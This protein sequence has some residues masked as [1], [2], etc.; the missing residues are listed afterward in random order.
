MQNYRDYLRVDQYLQDF[1]QTQMLKGALDNGL[2]DALIK[3]PSDFASLQKIS[4]TDAPGLSFLLKALLHSGVIIEAGKHFSLSPDFIEVLPYRSLI[5]AKI[6]FANL[7]APDLLEHLD[8]LLSDEEKFMQNSHLFE[9]FDYQRAL[10]STPENYRF[11]ERW[12]KLT[13]TLTRYEG[14]ACL[15]H[16]DFSS[17]QKIMDIGGNSGE[18]VLQ[19]TRQYAQLQAIVIDLPV[20]CEVGSQHVGN[21]REAERIQFIKADALTDKLPEEQ[22]LVSFKSILHDWPEAACQRFIEQ[23]HSSLKDKGQVL[24]F[25]RAPI[26]AFTTSPSYGSLS[27]L[28]FFRSYR[29]ADIYQNLLTC[30][31]FVDIQIQTIALETP[32]Y[33]I[34]A[35]KA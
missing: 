8:S 12:M 31:G 5:E 32:F 3:G 28:L 23:A 33:L 27:T 24:I 25:E 4:A 17:Y 13:S 9:L 15:A 26:P 2:I 34:T 14:P 35:R 21:Y 20:V 6:F 1:M 18:F 19:I 16:H 11:T 30:A 10:H 7:L 29:P 22:C